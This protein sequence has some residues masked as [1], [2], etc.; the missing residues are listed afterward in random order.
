MKQKLIKTKQQQPSRF[1]KLGKQLR[2]EVR[3]RRSVVEQELRKELDDNIRNLRAYVYKATGE[4]T[5]LDWSNKFKGWVEKEQE[6][7]QQKIE[8]LFSRTCKCE[9]LPYRIEE[10]KKQHEALLKKITAIESDL[11]TLTNDVRSTFVRY[12]EEM[13]RFEHARRTT[14]DRID[15]ITRTD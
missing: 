3:A 8:M 4:A 2:E 13:D 6:R 1:A 12:R 11:V 15:F 9:Q 10:L 7:L 14:L 5:S